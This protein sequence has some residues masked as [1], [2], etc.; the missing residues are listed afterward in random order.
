MTVWMLYQKAKTFQ[1]K[2]SDAFGIQSKWAAWQFDNAVF[3]LGYIVE[4]RRSEIDKK[5]RYKWTLEEALCI[6][7]RE[8]ASLEALAM[9]FGGFAKVT[10][11]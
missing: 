6:K 10:Q 9:A 3:A 1:S 5:G 8:Y 2:P 11:G 4:G 7:E